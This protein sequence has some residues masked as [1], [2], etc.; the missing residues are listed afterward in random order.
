MPP[1]VPPSSRS[2]PSTEHR[3]VQR[4][5]KSAVQVVALSTENFIRAHRNVNVDV[6]VWATRLAH[7]ALARELQAQTVF[8]T[9]WDV[10]IKGSARAHAT[11]PA[12]VDTR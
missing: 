6:A 2:R 12:A 1:R 7:F 8:D 10:Q 9:T 5:L 11:L 4:N 3:V